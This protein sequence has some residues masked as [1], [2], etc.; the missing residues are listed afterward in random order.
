MGPRGRRRRNWVILILV[1]VSFPVLLYLGLTLVIGLM[2][3]VPELG[4]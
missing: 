4:S 3:N 2:L 1:A